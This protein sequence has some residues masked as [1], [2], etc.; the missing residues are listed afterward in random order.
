[1]YFL[2][3]SI[4]VNNHLVS[5]VVH[6]LGNGVF[7]NVLFLAKA[8]LIMPLS[9]CSQWE[10]DTA[11]PLGPCGL[12]LGLV[13]VE[14]ADEHAV[15]VYI[16]ALLHNVCHTDPELL[17]TWRTPLGIV[18][19][20]IVFIE[21]TWS[22]KC[23]TPCDAVFVGLMVVLGFL[24]GQVTLPVSFDATKTNWKQREAVLH[25]SPSNFLRQ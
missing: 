14:V 16:L 24:D 21:V 4:N 5:M 7:T 22:G 10:H 15:D 8:D 18:P 9:L 19:Q 25:L 12:L 1:M 6:K 13:P 17:S 11:L 20:V 2:M 23:S 3:T